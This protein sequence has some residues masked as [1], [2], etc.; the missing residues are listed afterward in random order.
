MNRIGEGFNRI[1]QVKEI[2]KLKNLKVE[3][4][5]SHLCRSDEDSPDAN[6]NYTKMQ[7]E[8]FNSL[9][10]TLKKDGYNVGKTHIQNS[11]GILR[12]TSES[13]GYS[14]GRIGIAMYGVAD[15]YKS[16]ILQN[17]PEEY[18]LKPTISYRCKVAL[19]KD[20]N[21]GDRVGYGGNFTAPDKIRI[22]TITMGYADGLFRNNS[23][24]G[25]KLLIK[26][27]WCT[28]IGNI[29][30]DMCMVQIPNDR[31]IQEG[32]VVNVFGWVDD[33]FANFY[34]FLRKM[35]FRMWWNNYQN[36]IKSFSN[37]LY[38]GEYKN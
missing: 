27:V 32:D 29:C 26:N 11:F 19:V 7:I 8:R 20:I 18:K 15:N 21:K 33:K 14:L 38:I 9:I 6:N 30:M 10:Y 4:I 35:L 23:K 5:F 24:N 37:L 16:T 36:S 25:L 3:G 22:A 1:E 31:N 17:L 28:I 13:N 12:Y 34:E 2:F